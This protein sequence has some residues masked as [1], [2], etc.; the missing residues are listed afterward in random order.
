MRKSKVQ[1]VS[2]ECGIPFQ[3]G[4]YDMML[5]KLL[6]TAKSRILSVILM[7]YKEMCLWQWDIKLLSS[8]RVLTARMIALLQQKYP[9][10][11]GNSSIVFF[12]VFAAPLCNLL[13]EFWESLLCPVPVWCPVV[14]S[15]EAVEPGW[16]EPDAHGDPSRRTSVSCRANGSYSYSQ[17][18]SKQ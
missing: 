15:G 7:I 8:L 14:F 10:V 6:R 13:S 2:Q 1:Y 17:A 4:S 11:A 5:I 12:S 18:Y 16:A 9:W 3:N